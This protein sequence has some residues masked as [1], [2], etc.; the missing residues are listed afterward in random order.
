MS[1]TCTTCPYCGVG[2]GVL[3]GADGTIKGDPDHP[4]NFGRLCSKGSAL[5]ETLD[6]EGR[7]LTPQI[8]GRR[9]SWDDALDLVA[10]KLSA[11]VAEHGPDSVAFYVS[12]Q[13]LTEDYYVA[14]KLMKGYIGS[15]N[16]DTN[17]RLCMASSVA[18][19][20][21][22]FGTDTV[23]VC[24]DDLEQ[25]DLIVLVGSNFAWC[26]PVLAQRVVAAKAARPQMKV[27]NV[28][29]RETA[30]T[31]ISDEHLKIAADGDAALFNGLLSY[32]VDN[33]HV[34]DDYVNQHVT[35]FDAAVAEAKQSDPLKSGV[36]QDELDRFYAN[37]AGTKKVL[38]IYSQGVNQSVVGTDK[39][40]SIINCHLATGRIGREGMG[41]FSVTGQPNAMGGREVGGLANML[42]NHLDIENADHRAAVQGAWNS[43]TI[44][45]TQGLKAVDLFE[46]CAAGKI[47][48]LWVMST[49]P[50]VSMPDADK[51]ADAIKAVPFTVVTDIQERTDTGDLAHVLLPA[52]GWG[53]KNGTVTNSERRIS[54]QR[55]FLP[56]P[57]EARPDWEIICDVAKRMGFDEGFN[58]ETPAQVFDEYT[59]LSDLSVDAGRDLDLSGLQGLSETAYAALKPVQW[60]VT[61]TGSIERFFADGGFFHT[62][63]KAKML[64]ITPPTAIEHLGFRL[65]TGRVRDQ[66][67]TMTRTGKSARLSAHLAEPYCEI[68]PDDAR[69]LSVVSADL[70][71]V[72]GKLFRALVTTRVARG[73]VFIPMH[74][75]RQLSSSVVN[76]VVECGTDPVS[77]QPALKH[78]HVAVEK[79]DMAWFGYAVG[80]QAMDPVFPYHAIARTQ[81]GFQ[82]EIASFKQSTDWEKT[83]GQVL[84]QSTGEV[85]AV[86]DRAGS[87]ARVAITKDGVIQGLFFASR[88]PVVVAR[89]FVVGLIGQP[90]DSLSALAGMAGADQPD[91]GPTVCACLNVGRNTLTDAIAAGVTSIDTLGDQTGAGTNCGSCRPEI[92]RLIAE[93]KLPMA[94]E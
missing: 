7:L 11:A 51:V 3:A 32:L 46:A 87:L 83:A 53:E 29:P 81:T 8:D 52:A 69:S 78:A 65:N 26:H 94:A 49:N 6:L 71:R 38:T 45:T 10:S 33:G 89:S 21:R 48:A 63:G 90:I 41:P 64:P 42:A 20:K 9:A 18:G 12:G 70:V 61:Q 17:S 50:A 28:D 92:G 24:Y 37:W 74:W 80:A 35:G 66:W 39:V 68:H 55:S 67:H 36:S 34:D 14:N 62:D 54:R 5:G 58:F 15:A 88:D 4:A 47:K 75:T 13:L 27:I 57:G 43:P 77:G 31:E 93:F 56:V 1:L 84:G 59:R 2:C 85:S 76:G 19:H 86:L 44:C 40:N 79:A 60:P 22:A 82:A 23:P 73:E 25:A 16:I 72:G 30:T 91:P